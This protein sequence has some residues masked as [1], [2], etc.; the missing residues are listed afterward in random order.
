MYLSQKKFLTK[1][2]L[3]SKYTTLNIW[4]PSPPIFTLKIGA[5]EFLESVFPKNFNPQI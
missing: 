3:T 1:A 5:Y 2:G 4:N